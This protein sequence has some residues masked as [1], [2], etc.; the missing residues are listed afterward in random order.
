MD[1]FTLCQKARVTFQ[2]VNQR[3]EKKEKKKNPDSKA[4]SKLKTERVERN[5]YTF[6]GTLNSQCQFFQ[7]SQHWPTVL[8]P[9]NTGRMPVGFPRGEWFHDERPVVSEVQVEV[10]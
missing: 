4:P 5:K 1:I 7:D 3:K 8:L 6:F 2:V 9:L 10:R